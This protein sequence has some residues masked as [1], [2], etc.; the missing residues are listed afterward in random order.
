[1]DMR[2]YWKVLVVVVAV[3]MIGSYVAL[4]QQNR[5]GS[6]RGGMM[7][8]GPRQTM[9]G[10]DDNSMSPGGMHDMMAQC[11]AQSMAHEAMVATSDGGVV[12][13]A[14][15]KLIK[16][17]SS[18]G[19]VKEVDLKVDYESMQAKM[20]KMMQNMPMMQRRGGMM[21][22]SDDSSQQ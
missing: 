19:L 11:M 18:L 2:R 10:G 21:R 8:R 14:A 9:M 20:Q 6:M 3:A 7:D 13:L 4:A 12:V 16:Y 17:D 22:G 5:D 1:M 15:G